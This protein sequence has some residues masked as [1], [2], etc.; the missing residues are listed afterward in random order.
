MFFDVLVMDVLTLVQFVITLLCMLCKIMSAGT[1]CVHYVSANDECVSSPCLNGGSCVDGF[2]M[3]VC[4]CTPGF[5]GVH[6]ERGMLS[7][8]IIQL[9]LCSVLYK[10][11]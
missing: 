5:T 9:F 7:L 6:C 4:K 10:F 8:V 1:T 3:Y 2:G 11:K